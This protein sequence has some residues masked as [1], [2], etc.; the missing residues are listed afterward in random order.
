MCLNIHRIYIGKLGARSVSIP[1]WLKFKEHD[2]LKSMFRYWEEAHSETF[3]K[4]I[5]IEK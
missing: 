5:Y 4:V 1:S 2:S 3:I